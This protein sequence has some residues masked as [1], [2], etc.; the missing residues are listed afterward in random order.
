MAATDWIEVGGFGF[1]GE[2][3]RDASD[4]AEVAGNLEMEPDAL[5]GLMRDEELSVGRRLFFAARVTDDNLAF[6]LLREADER[7]CGLVKG[8]LE[9]ARRER[10]GDIVC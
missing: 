4:F 7:L 10:N 9:N 3:A 1:S 5:F 6:M 2:E 8:R